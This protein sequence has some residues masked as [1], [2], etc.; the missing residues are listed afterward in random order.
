MTKHEPLPEYRKAFAGNQRV[1][2]ST[3]IDRFEIDNLPRVAR[4]REAL[5]ATSSRIEMSLPKR[6]RRKVEVRG[7]LY[8][9]SKGSRGDNGRGVATVQHE[10][11]TGSRLMIDPYGAILYDAIP[12]AIE[13]RVRQ[14]L[15][16]KRARSA[17]LDWL[18]N[19]TIAS[20]VFRSSFTDRSAILERCEP[21]RSTA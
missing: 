20:C 17:I 2:R 8:H 11:G 7:D 18:L 4:L 12:S 1:N 15:E 21:R 10:S 9:W 16:S 3:R 13:F 14:W 19:N 6:N 5:P